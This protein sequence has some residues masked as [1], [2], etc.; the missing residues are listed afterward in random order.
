MADWSLLKKLCSTPGVSGAEDQV[1]EII[2]DE[3]KTYA[4]SVE[5]TPLGNIIAM[6]KGRER[7]RKKLII[8]AHMDEV[9]F[10]ITCIR[11]DG[12]LKIASV[13]GIN[14]QVI[15]GRPVEIDSVHG[16][17]PGVI[18]AK[19]IHLLNEEERGKAVPL[20]DLYIDIGADS[21][22]EA[23]RFVSPGDR[24]VFQSSW[25]E[26]HGMLKGRALDD[27]AGC[28][29]LIDLIKQELAYDMF[30][31]FA[32]QE[33]SGQSGSRTAAQILAPDAAIVVEAT[34][35]G[36]TAGV[37]EDKKV[38]SVGKGP[39]ITFMDHGTIYDREYYHLAFETAQEAGIHCQSKQGVAGGNDARVIHTSGSGVRSLAVS[40]PC[41][42]LHSAVGM[43]SQRDYQESLILLR[44]VAE[45]IAGGES[46]AA[47]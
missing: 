8:D 26:R 31:V 1:R 5:I 24:V 40:L 38:C 33:E 44:G 18:G 7:A 36:D 4:D 2:L 32:V 34:T 17:I 3:I 22:E 39:V 10:I 35:A 6:K 13:G 23:A 43:I 21:K 15:P 37:D 19:P 9:G 20:K 29:L 42:Y 41:R 47:K 30:F 12:L 25:D 45:K 27:R 28:A 14:L 46:P 11:D 16:R